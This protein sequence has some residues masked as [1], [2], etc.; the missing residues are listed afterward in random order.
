MNENTVEFLRGEGGVSYLALPYDREGD[1][2]MVSIDF[3]KILGSLENM[4]T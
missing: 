2:C 1:H 4:E 3:K